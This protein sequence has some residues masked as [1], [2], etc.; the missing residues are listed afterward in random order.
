MK[1]EILENGFFFANSF[2]R[3]GLSFLCRHNLVNQTS[4]APRI[5]VSVG[6]WSLYAMTVNEI[7]AQAGGEA[8]LHLYPVWRPVPDQTSNMLRSHRVTVLV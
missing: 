2:P 5:T 4:A 1:Q 8:I 3:L 7:Y 6:R